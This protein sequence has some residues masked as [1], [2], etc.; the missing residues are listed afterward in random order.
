MKKKTQPC[1][2]L[3]VSRGHGAGVVVFDTYKVIEAPLGVLGII[4]CVSD[5]LDTCCAAVQADVCL[6]QTMAKHQSNADRQH[7]VALDLVCAQQFLLVTVEYLGVHVAQTRFLV[8]IVKCARTASDGSRFCRK[9][10]KQQ[11]VVDFIEK[12]LLSHEMMDQQLHK[13]QERLQKPCAESVL[14]TTLCTPGATTTESGQHVRGV[15][16]YDFCYYSKMCSFC[17][18]VAAEAHKLHVCVAC[19]TEHYCNRACQKKHWAAEHKVECGTLHKQRQAFANMCR[20]IAA[21]LCV[22]TNPSVLSHLI[23]VALSGNVH[24]AGLHDVLW[25]VWC[26]SVDHVVL[27]STLSLVLLVALTLK[28]GSC[29]FVFDS[30]R[31]VVR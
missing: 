6:L 14:D 16:F 12:T 8:M 4:Q 19:K 9:P 31:H 26:Q 21:C 18:H 15:S 7:C 28:R 11:C 23:L 20:Q 30:V 3:H 17:C 1:E 10:D 2:K 24:G 25:L 29:C 22:W 5:Q 13:A 27:F